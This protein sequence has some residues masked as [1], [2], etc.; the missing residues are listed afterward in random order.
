MKTHTFPVFTA[1]N[2]MG[3]KNL[4]IAHD[5]AVPDIYIGSALIVPMPSGIRE[6]VSVEI[7]MNEQ[8]EPIRSNANTCLV[9]NYIY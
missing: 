4:L 2:G 5:P 1:T 7:V 3:I 9:L 8:G 6:P